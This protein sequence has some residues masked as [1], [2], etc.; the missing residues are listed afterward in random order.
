MK[1]TKYKFASTEVW[2]LI[3]DNENAAFLLLPEGTADDV[4]YPW[5]IPNDG[6]D[7]RARKSHTWVMGN[8][9]YFH[10][11]EEPTDHSPLTLKHQGLMYTLKFQNQ[12]LVETENK[13]SVV[14][15][16]KSEKGYKVIHT[17]TYIKGL[18]GFE[19][20]TEFVNETDGDVTLTMLSSFALDALSPYQSD[21]APCK[22]KLH[23]F[24]GGWSM[25][26]RHQELYAEDLNLDK[27][28]AGFWSRS[29]KFGSM[30]SYPTEKYFPTA[31]VEDIEAGVV[32][33]AGICHNATWQMEL[34]REGDILSFTGGLGDRD[35]CG[36][37]KILKTGE[38]LKAPKA[39]IAAVKG[40]IYDATA[41][42][43][44]MQKPAYIKQNEGGLPL[45]FNEFCT[46]WGK[47]TQ[48]NMLSYT[49]KLKEFGVKYA[50]ID[51]GWSVGSS[52]QDSNGDWEIDTEI[53]PDMK[54][55]CDTMRK[56]GVISGIWFEFEVTTKGARVYEKKYD[57]MHL[58]RDGR[59]INIY[60]FRTY[61]DFR[62]DDVK[63]YLHEKVT[64]LLKDN[65]F[66]YIKVDYNANIGIS[67][68]GAESGAEELRQHLAA[69]REFFCEMK[70][71][72]PDLI[73]E[74]CASGGHR[75][76]PSMLGISALSSFSDAH[77]GVEIPYIAANLHSV[78]LPAQ[79]LIWAVLHN[80]DSE[81]RE[82]YSLCA[83]FLGRVCLSGQIDE[84]TEGQ[85]EILKEAL[86]FYRKLDNI[87]INGDSKIYG[88]RGKSMR[89]PTGTQVV[90][91]K[92]D[93]E[94][95]VVCHAFENSGDK[96][97]IEIPEGFKVTDTFYGDA[98]NVD[99]CK[100]T[101]G[102]MADFSAGAILLKRREQI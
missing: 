78:M 19:V 48:A 49:K 53:F 30:G 11:A 56:E 65:G 14:T 26:A 45:C 52:G 61:W 97:T 2:Y 76:E 87:I 6:F 95:L 73:I 70:R 8:L 43:V 58:K 67:I 34:T 36:W 90:V 94:M 20:D 13:S 24:M 21:D 46:T 31:A 40:D 27:T 89:N 62:R 37:N 64:K 17:L 77:E 72:I 84:L 12:E 44:D 102:K 81:Q 86:S 5:D 41:A 1:I 29:E 23:R 16:L 93:T 85:E 100:L 96:I 47:P 4:K 79:E 69:V 101:I 15:T 18:R 10:M 38:S 99:G 22:Y 33:A 80:D 39:Y 51:A 75:L 25:E 63:E 42:I 66:G 92:T 82:V 59:V 9:A 32:W 68:D 55:M 7:A 74:N 60:D 35:F 98:I 83:T 57:H 54:A 3:N 71:E 50:V 88:T 91:R 28:W